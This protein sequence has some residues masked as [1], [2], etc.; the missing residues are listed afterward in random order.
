MFSDLRFSASAYCQARSRLP[1]TVLQQ[2]LQK[3]SVGIKRTNTQSAAL[4]WTK[5]IF[6]MGTDIFQC[7]TLLSYEDTLGSTVNKKEGCGFP[8]AHFIAL[9]HVGTG[10]ITEIFSGGIFSH[11]LSRFIKLHSGLRKRMLLWEQC[12]LLLRTPRIHST[13]RCRCSFSYTRT[14]YR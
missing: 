7:L 13:A 14:P 3:M 2:L 1:V 12:F 5:S 8:I 4:A 11:D 6:A 9:V 10:M